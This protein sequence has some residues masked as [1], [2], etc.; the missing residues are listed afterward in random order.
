MSND[1][2]SG[3][4]IAAPSSGSGKTVLTLALL[5]ALKDRGLDI[6]SAK[7]GPDYIDPAF[8]AL[9]SG[10]ASVNLDPWAMTP[11]RF[12]S[13]AQ[14]QQGSHLLIEGM[15]GLFDGAADGTGSAAELSKALGVPIVLIIDAAKQSH[16][17]AALVRGFRDHD[18]KVRLAGVILNKVGSARHKK[19]LCD[20]LEAIDVNVLGVIPRDDSFVLPERH[21]GLVQAGETEDIEAFIKQAAATLT[22]TCDLE[23]IADCFTPV[24]ERKRQGSL[25]A[26]LGQEIAIAQDRAFSFIYPHLLDDW[27]KQG[28]S[29]SFFSPLAN[30]APETGVNAI[31]L[32]GGYPELY[33]GQ[34]A[35]ADDFKFALEIARDRET[36]IYGECG[37]YMVLGE[38]IID[39]DG[40]SHAMAGLLNLET[41]FHQRKLHLGYRDLGAQDFPF[42]NDL[43]AH[44]FH[45]TS[46]IREEGEPLFQATDALGTDLGNAGLRNQNVMGSYMHIIDGQ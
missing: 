29:L 14:R 11:P 26:P 30:E 16:S 18:E 1:L 20:A 13:L 41:S 40:K 43:K 19:M 9:A 12:A 34:L 27:R 8:H 45:Y 23:K 28:A 2:K 4:L 31:Y 36:L 38:G 33:A 46:A 44:E 32:P 37:G 3:L 17:I 15:M 24:K 25:L 42:G 10:Y 6:A 21:L 35:S 39:A 5:R 7:A 22:K